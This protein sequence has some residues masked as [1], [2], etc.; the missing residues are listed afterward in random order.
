MAV[1]KRLLPPG[2]AG[3]GAPA[4][5]APAAGPAS[6]MGPAKGLPGK[7]GPAAPGKGGSGK[8]AYRPQPQ[9]FGQ[10]RFNR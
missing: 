4:D 6:K 2:A 7:G 5:D 1:G 3:V 8:A 10:P 9:V